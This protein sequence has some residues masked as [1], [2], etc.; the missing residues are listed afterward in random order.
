[1]NT[2]I[3]TKNIDGT[4]CFIFYSIHSVKLSVT[5]SLLRSHNIANI[6]PYI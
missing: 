6:L 5:E 2:K 4:D 3:M 1:G